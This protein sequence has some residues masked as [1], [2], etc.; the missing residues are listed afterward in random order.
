M[1]KLL[2]LA[3]I[4]CLSAIS[5][6]QSSKKELAEK[7]INHLAA[8]KWDSAIAMFDESLRGQLTPQTL[9]QVWGGLAGQLGKFQKIESSKAIGKGD[10]YDVTA[11]FE[12]GTIDLRCPF[13]DKQFLTGFF[14]PAPPRLKNPVVVVYLDAPY[15]KKD[16]VEDQEIVVQT[17]DFKL[18][19]T[20]TFPK[21]A[22]SFPV[23][24]LVHGSGPNDRDET[25]SQNKIFRDLAKGLASVGIGSIRYDKRTKVY[26]AKLDLKTFT[27]KEEV[28]DDVNSAIALAKTLKGVNPNKIIVIGHSLGAMA[29][30]QIA[31]ENPNLAG[32][33]LMAGNARPLGDLLIEQYEYLTNIDRESVV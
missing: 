7:F 28:I 30:P 33:V 12:K 8:S 17:G 1:K 20:F 31:T 13:N 6:A 18:P 16:K 15:T 11:G 21:N 19:G 23:V 26:G 27:L 10:V 24:I 5:N 2:L 9:E 29:A 14:I 3:L 32:I 22:I 4:S 25:Y